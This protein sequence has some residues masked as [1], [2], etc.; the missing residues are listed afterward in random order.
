MS[1]YVCN[2]L[3]FLIDVQAGRK[4]AR[5]IFDVIPLA[6]ATR[7]FKCTSFHLRKVKISSLRAGECVPV[8]NKDKE[9]VSKESR[10]DCVRLCWP[11]ATSS[12]IWLGGV[13][14]P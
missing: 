14:P 10:V 4:Y 12:R 11:E 6:T 8:K 3:E 13:R 2:L 7:G 5:Y 1:K 9:L